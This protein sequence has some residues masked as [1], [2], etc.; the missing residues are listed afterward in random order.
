[1]GL[2]FKLAM[3]T[4]ALLGVS[5]VLLVLS[6]QA[7]AAVVS[8]NITTP[9][10]P[11]YIQRNNDNAADP[12]NTFAISGTTVDD[13]TPGN[14]DLRCYYGTTS[15]PVA[16]NVAVTYSGT[17]GTF[18]TMHTLVSNDTEHTCTLRA[19]PT[20][21]TPANVSPF[22]GPVLGIGDYSASTYGSGPN[23]GQVYS[24]Y[25]NASQTAGQGDFQ[26]YGDGGMYD[27]YPI[28]PS[29]FNEGADEFYANDTYDALT[30]T[31]VTRSSVQVDGA[32]AFGAAGAEEVCGSACALPGI[33]TLTYT[34]SLDPAT[35]NLT[36]H[37]SEP[38]VKCAPDASTYPPTIGT[39]CTSFVP[40]GVT[41]NRTIYQ[42]ANG[43][44]SLLTDSY[45]STTGA[46]HSLDLISIEDAQ[47]PQSPTCTTGA[48]YNFPWVDGATT[49]NT[50]T[51]GDTEPAP[52]SAPASVYVAW[53]NSLADGDETGAQGAITFGQKPNGF[54]F[55]A[56]GDSGSTHLTALFTR[57]VPAS[58]STTLTQ[59]FSWAFTK[60]DA[61]A[62][63]A[64]AQAILGGPAV[65]ITSPAN[66]SSKNSP[67][68]VTGTAAASAGQGGLASL[69]VNGHA[70][71]VAAN[72]TWSTSLALGPGANTITAIATD[73]D[74]EQA[75]AQ[76]TV[77]AV[78]R[79]KLKGK[80]FNGKAVLLKLACASNGSN[81]KGKIT[82]RYTETVVTTRHGKKHRHKVTLVVGSA[83]YSVTA[84]HS[85]T[86]TVK[87]KGNGKRLLKALHKLP[88]KGTV[89]LVQPNGRSTKAIG[90]KLTLK[91]VKKKK[92][93]H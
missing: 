45:V 39:S 61:H 24:F 88:V 80:K 57:T 58:G 22:V 32:N 43:R 85:K 36:I 34:H 82:L 56:N 7:S 81:C 72:G 14:V 76:I 70:V 40:T 53:D 67:V 44:Q 54:A 2:R 92:H 91:P 78:P 16:T 6:G 11:T 33:P 3:H 30:N 38:L 48:G 31:G 59:A 21:T 52:A 50:H 93:H 23:A 75:Q 25:N 90:F 35:G 47:C 29:T 13:G 86:I 15:I 77:H 66:G 1:M 83:S 28:D 63:A 5:T 18:S 8:S 42:Y 74:G 12:A 71:S 41:L 84:G 87:L 10:N 26:T 49:Y 9:S 68:T 79:V 62:L 46:S 65:A 19:I 17:S 64:Q 20:S 51:A 27:A 73:G 60:A 37:E 89:T 69:T 55:A 4:A